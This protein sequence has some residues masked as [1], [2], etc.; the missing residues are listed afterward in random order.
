MGIFKLPNHKK[1]SV[2]NKHHPKA[3]GDKRGCQTNHHN[4]SVDN[5]HHPKAA[6]DKRGCQTNHHNQSVKTN[7]HPKAAGQRTIPVGKEPAP[8]TCPRLLDPTYLSP[9][10]WPRLLGNQCEVRFCS[11]LV[12]C[13]VQ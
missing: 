4:Q 9:L 3:A 7:R 5:K 10:T 1:E 11:C 12:N 8:L 6:G 13:G 2:D